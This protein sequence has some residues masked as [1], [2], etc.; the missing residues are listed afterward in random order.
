MTPAQAVAHLST[1]LEQA[2]GDQKPK[3]MMLGYVFGGL[4][5]KAVFSDGPMK[6][7]TP[8]APSLLIKDDRD[9]DRERERLNKL[10]DRAAGGPGSCTFHPHIF[11]GE[12]SP[13]EWGKL[14]YKHLDHHLQ[15]FGV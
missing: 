7:N 8:T 9:L 15:Q 12:L 10:I 4:A 6:R 13:D 11:F 1:S 2:L 5:K 14:M 3:R